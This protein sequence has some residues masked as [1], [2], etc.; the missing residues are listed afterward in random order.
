MGFKALSTTSALAKQ[1]LQIVEQLSYGQVWKIEAAILKALE[2]PS[3]LSTS[4]IE[5]TP[6]FQYRAS[7]DSGGE[8]IAKEHASIKKANSWLVSMTCSYKSGSLSKNMDHALKD[9]KAQASLQTTSDILVAP[10]TSQKNFT[11]VLGS[12]SNLKQLDAVANEEDMTSGV[13]KPAR[14]MIIPFRQSEAVVHK[15]SFQT[16]VKLGS[17]HPDAIAI[18]LGRQGWN[19]KFH[20]VQIVVANGLCEE[21]LSDQ[22][23][24]A[25]CKHKGLI[26]CGFVGTGPVE[27]WRDQLPALFSQLHCDF[28]LFVGVDYT[29]YCAGK[30]YVL[31]KDSKRECI[32]RVTLSWTTQPRDPS[33]KTIYNICWIHELGK[34]NAMVTN[35]K[36][37][38]ALLKHVQQEVLQSTKPTGAA[39]VPAEVKKYQVFNVPADGRCG[40]HSILA[41]LNWKQFTSVPRKPCGYATSTLLVQKEES[42]ALA[43]CMDVCSKAMATC[44]S[45]FYAA[46][47]RVSDEHQFH[48]CDLLWIAPLVGRCIRCTCS[49][50]ARSVDVTF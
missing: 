49:D 33:Q 42:D 20:A 3:V 22:T 11:E 15:G 27:K 19:S 34:T 30:P 38:E 13:L 2:F 50:E 6:E 45:S 21:L 31:E 8:M 7:F 48:P 25:A 17:K 44:D 46:I 47:S 14:K 16:F 9:V 1:K 28:P 39:A 37:S 23:V 18:M 32:R 41:L 5:L 29:D 40:W 35:E 36:V 24:V 4:K 10:A 43:L 26:P 12:P